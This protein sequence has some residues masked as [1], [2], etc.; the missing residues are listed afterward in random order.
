MGIKFVY[1]S[2]LQNENAKFTYHVYSAPTAKNKTK[3]TAKRIKK[4]EKQYINAVKNHTYYI[5]VELWE[6]SDG[7]SESDLREIKM[8]STALV[9]IK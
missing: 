8:G 6:T 5:R 4:E 9:W 3:S 1:R 2:Y 7:I